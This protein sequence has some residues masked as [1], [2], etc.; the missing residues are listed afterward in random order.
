M[1][2][3]RRVPPH[4]FWN[5]AGSLAFIAVASNEWSPREA[6]MMTAKVML[7]QPFSPYCWVSQQIHVTVFRQEFYRA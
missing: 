6:H 7:T 4:F 3:F 1:A 5:R 2:P